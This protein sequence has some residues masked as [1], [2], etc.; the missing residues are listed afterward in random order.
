MRLGCHCCATSGNNTNRLRGS[1]AQNGHSPD[2]T[3]RSTRCIHSCSRLIGHSHHALNLAWIL[4]LFK[5]CKLFL[6]GC[7]VSAI[8]GSASARLKLAYCTSPSAYPSQFLHLQ[9]NVY[10]VLLQLAGFPGRQN[11]HRNGTSKRCRKNWVTAERIVMTSWDGAPAGAT[12]LGGAVTRSVQRACIGCYR[13]KPIPEMLR[14][15][16]LRRLHGAI[17]M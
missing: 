17:V 2:N 14:Q 5:S 3:L 4:S 6:V 10:R 7:Q 11:W 1:S 8:S 13:L 15:R 16:Q 12:V 9:A